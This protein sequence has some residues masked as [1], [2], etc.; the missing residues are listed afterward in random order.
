M[1]YLVP[2]GFIDRDKIKALK[3]KKKYDFVELVTW[4]NFINKL[5]K[6]NKDKHSDI[7]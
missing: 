5:E 7:R 3:N 2:D 6:Y 4:E 1:V